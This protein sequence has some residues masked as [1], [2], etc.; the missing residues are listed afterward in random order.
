M[1]LFVTIPALNEEA[2]I[3]DVIR[4]IPRTIAGVDEVRVLV[5]DDGST[6]RTSEV[7]REAGAD[8]V[9]RHPKRKGLAKTFRDLLEASLRRGADII[10]NTDAD[11]HYNQSRIGDLVRPILENRAEIVI[12]SRKVEELESMP[13]WN[14]H[15]N[16]LGSF[17]TTRM[18]NLPPVDV[19]TGFRAYSR[20]A[21]LR[22]QVFSNHTYTHTTLIS[23]SDQ[24]LS[25]VEV[26][27]KARKVTR[28]SRLIPSIPHFIMNAGAI[29]LRNLILFKPLR[30][31][32]LLGGVI[33]VIGVIGVVRFLIYYWFGG[34]EGHIQ[35]LVL[36]GVLIIVGFQ[37]GIMGLIAS[38]IGWSRRLTEEALYHLRVMDY[39]RDKNPR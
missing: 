18:G 1:K 26:P 16:R 36:S 9:L 12:G 17:I 24:R 29:I 4:E 13:F 15:L 21:A 7:A 6:D 27:I 31:F 19:S 34:G 14:K 30:F 38:A 25:I 5:Y 32:G 33:S 10:V 28:K 3:G 39:D 20:E 37:V 35:S 11:N 22:I 2:T 8:I 23:A